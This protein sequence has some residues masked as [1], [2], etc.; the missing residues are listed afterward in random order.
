MFFLAS[1]AASDGLLGKSMVEKWAVWKGKKGVFG[2]VASE[3]VTRSERNS[4]CTAVL[5]VLAR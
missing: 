1:Y 2:R 5:P 4:C 3:L